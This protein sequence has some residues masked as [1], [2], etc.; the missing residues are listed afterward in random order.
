M[1]ICE[2][3]QP[4][5]L[6]LGIPMLGAESSNLQDVEFFLKLLELTVVIV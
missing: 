4:V 5:G 1:V 3:V 2:C 6:F